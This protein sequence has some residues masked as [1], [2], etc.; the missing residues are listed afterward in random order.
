VSE[1]SLTRL[2]NINASRTKVPVI[3]LLV[4]EL[5]EVKTSDFSLLVDTQVHAG[6]VLD[7]HEQDV[8]DDE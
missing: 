3:H 1:V 7:D 4:K 2:H 8:A 5:V 6:D